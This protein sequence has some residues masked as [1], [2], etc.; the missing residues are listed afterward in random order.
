MRKNVVGKKRVDLS[1][2]TKEERQEIIDIILEKTKAKKKQLEKEFEKE[3]YYD[4][5]TDN[6]KGYYY[7]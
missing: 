7:H 1:K 2:I 6:D 4:D 3:Y 5:N